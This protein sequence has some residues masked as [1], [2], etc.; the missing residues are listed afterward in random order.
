LAPYFRIDTDSRSPWLG[1][2]NIEIDGGTVTLVVKAPSRILIIKIAAIGDVIMALP[3]AREVKR[4]YPEARLSWIV[5]RAAKPILEE[6]GFVD[7]IIEVDEGAILRGSFLSKIQEVVKTWFRLK[8]MT[9]DLALNL[10]L[11]ERY[12]MLL[13]ASRVRDRRQ[14]KP[15]PGRPHALNNLFLLSGV[16]PSH[17][18]VDPSPLLPRQ[19]TRH[20]VIGIAPGGA[21]NVA[22]DDFQR[23]WP[24]EQYRRLCEGLGGKGYK[25]VI[26]GGASDGWVSPYFDGLNVAVE[27]GKY[28]LPGFLD[29][30][31]EIEVLVTHD[32]GPL[33][34]A[35]AVG[36]KVVGLFG[37][38][39]ARNVF[40][41]DN[42]GTAIELASP[43][44]CQPC[45]NNFEY[46]DCRSNDCMK[47]ISVEEVSS[48]VEH[49]MVQP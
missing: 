21:R 47:M 27:V 1:T 48:T 19:R 35:H 25:V 20:R 3:L 36:T 8:F 32:S 43:L 5:G 13:A 14:L 28:N 11:D 30:L 10:H 29:R 26:L 2:L 24:V 45:Y 31:A 16:G 39:S 41:R 9:F 15:S 7:D 17:D 34:M 12:W 33:H 23:R 37:P 38:T 6:S 22:R 4:L 46:G 49:Y 42:K 40:P 18:Q 44:P